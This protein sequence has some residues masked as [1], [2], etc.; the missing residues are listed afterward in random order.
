MSAARFT[1]DDAIRVALDLGIAEFTMSG[2]ARELGV[3]TPAIYRL[4]PN[5]DVLV[6]DCFHQISTEISLAPV[7]DS[8]REIL[9]HMATTTWELFTR[10]P[11]FDEVFF[12]YPG[13]MQEVWPAQEDFSRKL[14]SFGYSRDQIAFV[15]MQLHVLTTAATTRLQRRI[16]EFSRDP[17]STAP[18]RT[19]VAQGELITDVDGLV[20]AERRHWRQNID[21]FLDHL[22][23]VDPEWPDQRGPYSDQVSPSRESSLDY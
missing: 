6:K 23:R 12:T 17:E 2:V 15:S 8:W 18:P 9:E 20:A 3:T 22:E 10:W 4:F 5:R 14:A 19:F 1:V 7:G 21:F 13:S 11:G 16:G